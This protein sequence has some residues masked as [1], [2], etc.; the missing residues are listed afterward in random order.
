MFSLRIPIGKLQG[1]QRFQQV[2]DFLCERLGIEVEV[3][4]PSE[5]L[6]GFT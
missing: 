4:G 2:V 6:S 5:G 3:L 1:S